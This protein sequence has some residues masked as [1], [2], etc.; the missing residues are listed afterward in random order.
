[1]LIGQ[2]SLEH[3]SKKAA[4]WNGCPVKL[5]GD[6]R[7]MNGSSAGVHGTLLTVAGVHTSRGHVRSGLTITSPKASSRRRR[8]TG[9]TDSHVYVPNT[10]AQS[11]PV[12]LHG[13][14]ITRHSLMSTHSPACLANPGAQSVQLADPLENANVP[15]AHTA[16]VVS[17]GMGVNRPAEHG[18]HV[19]APVRLLNVPAEQ[20]VHRV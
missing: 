4:T 17:P 19:V 16:H 12:S 14:A 8:A 9:T 2:D 7:Q 6:D 13:A 1:M 15:A 20:L 18:I 5:H 3:G 10:L 11:V